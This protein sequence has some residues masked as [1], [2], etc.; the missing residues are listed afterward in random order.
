MKKP[1]NKNFL[2]F[3][4]LNED[5]PYWWIHE[6]KAYTSLT[7]PTLYQ[8][9]RTCET[10]PGSPS[11]HLMIASSFLFVILIGVEKLIVLN[12]MSYRRPLRYLARTIFAFILMVLAVSRMYFATHFLHQCILG[13]WLG[14][15]VSE[16]FSF[17]KYRE[18][19]QAFEKVKWFKIGC[20]MAVSVTSIFWMYK[21]FN[22][23]PME[24]VQLVC[25]ILFYE[26]LFIH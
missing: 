4:I 18:A 19:V 8:T 6:T 7:R 14:I 16:I 23:N 10:S 22:G 17:M 20:A 2:H 15:C 26:R 13:A 9:E 12:F 24:S 21:M 1:A 11:G 5:R 25:L 3:R